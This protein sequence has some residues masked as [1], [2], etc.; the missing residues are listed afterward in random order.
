MQKINPQVA[1]AMAQQGGAIAQTAINN[2]ANNKM[3]DRETFN[4]RLNADLAYKRSLDYQSQMAA[5]KDAGINPYMVMDK[6]YTAP[7]AQSAQYKPRHNT[8]LSGIS[9][10]PM[11][12]LQAQLIQAQT[13]NV[14][15]NTDNT[16]KNTEVTDFNLS[17]DKKYANLERELG[18]EN[19][20]QTRENLK[21]TNQNL[22][23]TKNLLDQQIVG[24]KT[25][26]TITAI[27]AKFAEVQKNLEVATSKQ[28]LE[29][30]KMQASNLAAATKQIN[31]L[32]SINQQALITGKIT[33]DQ[34][35]AQIQKILAETNTINQIRQPE[36]DA[37][38]RSNMG[39]LG[40]F[41]KVGEDARKFYDNLKK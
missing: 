22:L 26:N 40:G 29:N 41:K 2:A 8:D 38:E 10:I 13:R 31:S 34:L 17:V 5:Y 3:Y 9:A 14:S 12:I 28:Q 1:A 25:T 15:A 23:S 33:Q 4:N 7:V 37:K 6:S 21:Q 24:Q 27:N 36:V 16:A 19:A 35:N 32:I 30:L 39:I 11:A 20:T 18:I